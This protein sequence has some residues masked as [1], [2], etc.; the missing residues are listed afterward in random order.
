MHHAG[1][2][3]K[4]SE[5][6]LWCKSIILC[7]SW[8]Y[9]TNLSDSKL[10]LCT[11][12]PPLR[13]DRYELFSEGKESQFLNTELKSSTKLIFGGRDRESKILLLQ[14][15]QHGYKQISN[16]RMFTRRMLNRWILL[17]K[18]PPEKCPVSKTLL[19][20]FPSSKCSIGECPPGH[21]ANFQ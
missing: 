21:Q 20:E 16:M 8:V 13:V 19:G 15:S 1:V 6:I 9:K 2:Y 11:S 12:L 4:N 5:L 18:C 14:V 10:I 17:G 3:L 7:R